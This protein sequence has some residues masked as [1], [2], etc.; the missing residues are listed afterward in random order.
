MKPEN[1]FLGES[2]RK[3]GDIAVI[4]VPYEGAC[5]VRGTA[6]GPSAIIKASHNLEPYDH[7]TGKEIGIRTVDA[8]EPEPTPEE[9]ISEVEAA[10]A[11]ELLKDRFPVMIG[12]CHTITLGAVKALD[13]KY[14]DI[15]VLSLDAHA[16][17]KDEFDG[18]RLSHA[19]VMAR[20]SEIC[21][22]VVVGV[23]NASKGEPTD[24]VLFARDIFGRNDWHN[25][26][27]SKLTDNVYITI[28]LDYFDPSIMA[29]VGTPE[30]GGLL[31]YETLE[32]L[33]KVCSEK[34]VVGFDIVELSPRKNN[35]ECDY[36]AAK[37]LY[38]V[39]AYKNQPC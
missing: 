23:R 17:M 11:A 31:W 22:A 27:L 13:K 7:E 24:N 8:L 6:D 20:V 35:P 30:P 29:S 33:R 19:S 5:S 9:M 36:L 3:D 1:V 12:G 25:G 21:N 4:P 16:D 38:K 18:T 14:K 15:S 34:N 39:L 37:L 26:V 2:G 28:D 10:V 32:F